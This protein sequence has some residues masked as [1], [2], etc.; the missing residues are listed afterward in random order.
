MGEYF[1][2]GALVIVVVGACGPSIALE[3]DDTSGGDDGQASISASAGSADGGASRPA[4]ACGVGDRGLFGGGAVGPT[5]FPPP[6]APRSDPGV[7]GYRCCSDDPAAVGGGLPAY[8][9]MGIEGGAP[10][11]SEANNE[12]SLF[13]QCVR[14]GDLVGQG[15]IAAGV[16]GCPIPCNPTWDA[17]S[18][19]TICGP[20]RVCCQTVQ[21]RDQDC[22][23]DETTGLSRPTSGDDIGILTAWRPGDHATHQDPNGDGCSGIAGGDTNGPIFLD[24]VRALSVADQRGFCMALGAGQSCPT[25]EPGYVDAC[26]ARNED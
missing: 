23:I 9:G 13:G 20:A 21:L 7:N 2:L 22:V 14:V 10:Y 1:G 18:I 16:E 6:C 3:T 17:G 15:L 5:G 12:V 24:C 25:E 8:E 19:Q 11:F 26:E 4:R